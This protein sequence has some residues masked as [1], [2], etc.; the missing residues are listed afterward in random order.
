MITLHPNSVYGEIST[1]YLESIGVEK[2]RILT[3]QNP[4]DERRYSKT[5][6][7]YQ[8]DVPHPRALFVGRLIE[9]KGIVPLLE[10]TAELQQA[11][12]EFSL[13]VVGGGP[14]ASRVDARA[15]ELG[16][17]HFQ[18]VDWISPE[19]IPSI[20]KACDFMVFPTYV[21]VWGLVVNEALLS[22]LPVISSIYAGCTYELLPPENIFDPLDRESFRET[23]E[24]AVRGEIA[25][26][27][28]TQLDSIYDVAHRIADNML[29]RR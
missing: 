24:R 26:A 6:P 21:D 2:D 5:T 23:Y 16:I 1:E 19:E 25:P 9:N 28:A 27:E 8:L 12:H 15:R 13:V 17:R 10:L 11:G 14:E 20:Y 7:P 22:G 18:R 3:I 4:V 29:A